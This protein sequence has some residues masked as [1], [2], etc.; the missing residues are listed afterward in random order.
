ME[1]ATRTSGR[2][3]EPWAPAVPTEETGIQEPF[4]TIMDEGREE[5]GE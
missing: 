3:K 2:R 1:G 4:A 5:E